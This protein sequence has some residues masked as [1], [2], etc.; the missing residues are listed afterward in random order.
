MISLRSESW[1]FT[2]AALVAVALVVA[3]LQLTARESSVRDAEVRSTAQAVEELSE[4]GY[5][6]GYSGFWTAHIVTY[7]ADQPQPIV[8]IECSAQ[9]RTVPFEWIADVGH[10]DDAR[11]N[12]DES[13]FIIVDHLAGRAL[14]CPPDVLRQLHGV[15]A[16]T[17]TIS[18]NIEIWLYDD[19]AILEG[20]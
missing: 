7:Y 17:M 12:P 15:P 19:N 18:E 14:T 4:A 1:R 6:Y 11:S 10:I 9:G 20:T 5:T 13:S 2:L 3:G 8:A 16:R